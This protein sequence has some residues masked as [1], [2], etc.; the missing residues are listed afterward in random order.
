M[1]SENSSSLSARPGFKARKEQRWW[2]TDKALAWVRLGA[3]ITIDELMAFRSLCEVTHLADTR[4]S[5]TN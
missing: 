1:K 3:F 4:F 2:E 5:Y